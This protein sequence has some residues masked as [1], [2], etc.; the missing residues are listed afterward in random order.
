[1]STV[2]DREPCLLYRSQ[3]AKHGPTYR[4]CGRRI[5]VSRSESSHPV[6][7]W[8][9]ARREGSAPFGSERG[10]LPFI[11]LRRPEDAGLVAAAWPFVSAA[12]FAAAWP[13]CDAS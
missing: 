11:P 9:A 4:A 2:G 1:R 13:F 12:P 8:R 7:R 5:D 3:P 10:G 6:G